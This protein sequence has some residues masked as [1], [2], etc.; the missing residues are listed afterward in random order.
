MFC[1]NFSIRSGRIIVAD[2]CI[3]WNVGIRTYGIVLHNVLDNGSIT[4]AYVRFKKTV[5]CVWKF[6]IMV[7]Y[8]LKF[9]VTPN[10]EFSWQ[11]LIM[12]SDVCM[13]IPRTFLG[14]SVCSCSGWVCQ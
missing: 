2:E 10:F 3:L 8:V 7:V 1:G 9:E 4:V 12:M 6:D 13:Q 5:A 11:A 14:T